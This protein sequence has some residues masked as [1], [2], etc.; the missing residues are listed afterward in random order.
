M[1]TRKGGRIQ[2]PGEE[3][4]WDQNKAALKNL[5]RPFVQRTRAKATEKIRL[6]VLI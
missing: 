6:R 3:G 1:A 2:A 5:I 4:A